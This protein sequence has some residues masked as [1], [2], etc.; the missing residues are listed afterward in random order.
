MSDPRKLIVEVT[1]TEELGKSVREG[2]I[3]NPLPAIPSPTMQF[4]PLN[5]SPAT[6]PNS[7]ANSA[8]SEVSDDT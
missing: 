5:Q 7:P 3:I 2:S 6:T 4:G 8:P 1:T